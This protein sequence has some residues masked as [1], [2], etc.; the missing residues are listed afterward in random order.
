MASTSAGTSE[1]AGNSVRC[2]D[3]FT[4][5]QSTTARQAPAWMIHSCYSA[6]YLIGHDP[7]THRQQNKDSNGLAQVHCHVISLLSLLFKPLLKTN[8]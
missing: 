6:I 1:Q 5:A 3:D 7:T 4:V 2:P 8:E